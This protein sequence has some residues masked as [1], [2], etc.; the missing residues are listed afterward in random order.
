MSRLNQLLVRMTALGRLQLLGELLLGDSGSLLDLPKGRP[1]IK[2]LKRDLKVSSPPAGAADWYRIYRSGCD[3]RSITWSG[4][5]KLSVVMP[6]YKV[7]PEWLHEAVQSVLNQSYPHWEF[8]GVDDGSEEPT[9]KNLMEGFAKSDHRI[10][11]LFLEKNVGVSQATNEGLKAAS[12]DYILFMDHDDF[13]EPHALARLADAALAEDS[14]IFV[15]DEAITGENINEILCIH[16]RPFFSYTYYLSHPYV[17]HPVMVRAELVRKIGGLTAALTI[18]QDIDFVL[19]AL[20]KS[21]AVTHV[22]DVLYRW[23]T[24]PTSAGHVKMGVVMETTTRLKTEHLQRLGFSGAVVSDGLSFNTFSVRYFAKPEGRILAVIR[25][26]N[27]VVLL[28][29]CIESVSKTTED[30]NIDF[31]VIDHESDDPDTRDYLRSLEQ[32]GKAS[33]L[34]Y[35]GIFNYSAINNKAIAEYGSGYDYFLFLNNDIEAKASGWLEAM[36]DLAMRSDVGAVGATLLYPDGTIQHSGVV[37]GMHGGADHLHK[38]LRFKKEDSGYNGSIHATRECS[39]VTG[40]CM[41]VPAEIFQQVDGFDERLRVGFNDID[42]C[43]RIRK[44]GYLIV[45]CAEAML[46]H[47]ESATRGK[48]CDGNDP[49]PADTGLFIQRH[50]DLIDGGDPYF[51]PLLSRYHTTIVL[52]PTARHTPKIR[53]RTVTDFLPK[54]PR[55]KSQAD[56]NEIQIGLARTAVGCDTCG[57]QTRETIAVWEQ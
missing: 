47:Y 4:S 16:A 3:Y 1:S 40:A 56:A 51:S 46:V 36:M 33:V 48:S 55:L 28:R 30:L 2:A 35:K 20:E 11:A 57:E 5:V 54:G 52:D 8:I 39:A 34:P 7:K 32:H 42:L 12:G 31:A 6:I 18:S 24:S 25:T 27:Q 49:H 15:A 23:R 44:E 43:L 26:K 17:V 9:L 29:Q 50:K 13:L 38:K 14:D 41:L 10:K 45:N 21:Q 37:I 22:P 19:R 53:Y